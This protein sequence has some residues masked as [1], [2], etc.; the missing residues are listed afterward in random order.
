[1][2]GHSRWSKVKHYKGT[3]DAKR[4][5]IF[6]KLGKE[7]AVACKHGGGDPGFNPRLRTILMK[8]RAMN[9]PAD[10][11]D[12]AIKKGT[13][14]LPGVTY[15]EITYEGY[16]PGGVA[17]L[18]ELLSDNKNRTAAEIRQIFTKHGGNMAVMGAVKHLFHRKGQ[19]LVAK[20]Q[21]SDFDQLLLVVLD[22]GA[23]D[24][25]THPDNYSILTDPHQIEVVHKALEAK[26]IKPESAEV[27]FLPLTPLPVMDEKTAR[28]VLALI[29][30]LEDS[31]DVQNVYSNCDIPDEIL[32]KVQAAA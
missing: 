1:M 25:I 24:M 19:I 2:S 10:N 23:E 16:G 5:K 3:I 29:D 20:E 21:I 9:M 17:L 32:E 7:M 4:G 27:A 11:I 30:A 12:R 6:A 18:M 13:G 26:G 22:A 28:S 15:E 14:E 8:A 31:D